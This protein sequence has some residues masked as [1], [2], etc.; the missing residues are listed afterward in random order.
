MPDEFSARFEV[1]KNDHGQSII[2]VASFVD[3]ALVERFQQYPDDLRVIDR[4]RFEELIAELFLGFGYEVELT[5]RTRDGG[6]DIIA[7]KRRTVNVKFLIECKRPDPENPIGIAPVRE[8]YGVKVDEG[9]SKAILATT[10]YFTPDAKIFSE[11]HRWELELRDFE[12]I[13]GW[14]TEYLNTR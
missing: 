14:I 4:R 12:A 8:L 6:K 1:E 11:K 5:Q 10:S 3:R 7:I 13:K 9:A 2:E